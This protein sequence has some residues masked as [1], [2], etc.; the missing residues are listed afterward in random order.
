[1]TPPVPDAYIENVVILHASHWYQLG[2]PLLFTSVGLDTVDPRTSPISSF[3]IGDLDNGGSGSDGVVGN[4]SVA[5][6][7][8]DV[9]LAID[10]CGAHWCSWD[11]DGETTGNGGST[12]R[13]LET[14]IC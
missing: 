13:M 1:M 12:G 11:R 5:T 6:G 9:A 2:L 14:R 3:G 4:G 7:Q 8:D 10:R